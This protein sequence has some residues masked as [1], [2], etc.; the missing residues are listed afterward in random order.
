MNHHR[1]VLEGRQPVN[2]VTW[3][4][5]E[6]FESLHVFPHAKDRSVARLVLVNGSIL[7]A[8]AYDVSG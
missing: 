6:W 7:W 1:V 4:T 2:V 5:P 8:D 3:P